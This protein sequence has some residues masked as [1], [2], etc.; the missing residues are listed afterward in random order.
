MFN[1]ITRAVI[2]FLLFTTHL[3]Y[4]AASEAYIDGSKALRR[5]VG[6]GVAYANFATH[7]FC[8]LNLVPLVSV[9]VTEPRECGKLCVDHSSC[10]STNLAAFRDQ[11]EKIMCELLPSDRY[12]NSNKFMSNA[13]FHHLSI[14]VRK[15]VYIPKSVKSKMWRFKNTLFLFVKRLHQRRS[16]KDFFLLVGLILM[17]SIRKAAMLVFD[18][19]S[20]IRTKSL[21]FPI[22]FSFQGLCSVQHITDKR[23]FFLIY[24]LEETYARVN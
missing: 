15:G 24:S 23:I 12:I 9:L 16:G 20:S 17:T 11:E 3:V 4:Q 19:N 6:K 14:K 21:N 2:H 18:F 8:H 7:K 1:L 5:D 10:F 22:R 13:T